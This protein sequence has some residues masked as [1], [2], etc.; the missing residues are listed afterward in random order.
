MA[1]AIYVPL[2]LNPIYFED[3]NNCFSWATF[4][5]HILPHTGQVTPIL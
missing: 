4:P 2:S 5:S 1:I 3:G